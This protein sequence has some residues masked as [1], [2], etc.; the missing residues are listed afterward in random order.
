MLR[1]NLQFRIQ[2]HQWVD[3]GLCAIALWFAH[4]LRYNY[5]F[6]IGSWNLASDP[7]LPF[8]P[9]YFTLFLVIIPM[10]PLVLEF[11]GF[12]KR[13]LFGS[14]AQSLWQLLRSSVVSTVGLILVLYMLKYET[15]RG[16]IIL[17]GVLS[18]CLILTKEE[19]V[20][21]AYRNKVGIA[22]FKRRVVLVGTGID[23]ERLKAQMGDLHEDMDILGSF[24]LSE[25]TLDYLVAFLHEHAINGVIFAAKHTS[26]GQV[27]KAIQACE[28]EGIDAWLV[29]DFFNTRISRTSFDELNGRPVLVFSS[30]PAISWSGIAKQ[31]IDL[32]GGLVLLIVLLP[33]MILAAIAIKVTSP[34]P[35]LFRQQRAGLN[36]KPFIMYKFRSMVTNAEQLKQELTLLNEMS[37]PV[38]KVTHDP[39]VTPVGKILR[40]FSIDE[41]P[42][43][44]NV[45]RCE[46]SLVGPRPLPVDEVERFDDVAHRRRLSVKPGL[47]CL[48]QIS[49]RNDLTDFNEWVRLDLQYIDNWSLWL[50]FKIL[51]RT[52]PVV[53][54]GKGAR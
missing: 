54:L 10:A 22:Q 48:W 11:Q 49:G 31:A 21:W 43:I 3:G 15:A 50:D 5:T 38:F 4:W 2:I 52:M 32:L 45:L 53:L 16:V 47:T 30:I 12:Y 29:A 36:G 44:F 35:V 24:D 6:K 18:F 41:F 8:F 34:G 42:Q 39:R 28:L 9:N 17:Y 23:T 33:F 37:G 27:E 26:F 51:W 19:L 13:T 20:R 40:K 14:R 25:V 7:I 1:R 46:M